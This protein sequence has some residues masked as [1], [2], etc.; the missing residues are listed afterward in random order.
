MTG[1]TR[2]KAMLN[3]SRHRWISQRK[4]C[5]LVSCTNSLMGFV[6][7][8]ERMAGVVEEDF[9]ETRTAI[10]NGAK[11]DGEISGRLKD[12][13][14]GDL[15]ALDIDLEAGAVFRGSFDDLYRGK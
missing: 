1:L 13:R 15:I 4:S 14:Q 8:N 6:L 11:G 2:L 12:L 7:L 10:G 5:P 3:G 9:I